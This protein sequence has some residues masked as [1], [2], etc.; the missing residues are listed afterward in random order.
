MAPRKK[1]DPSPGS[2]EARKEK[3]VSVQ[4]PRDLGRMLKVVADA[5]GLSMG[6]LL[7]SLTRE[8]VEGKVRLVMERMTGKAGEARRKTG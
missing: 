5:E 8:I 2:W 7:D 3:F 6:Q 4:V 1:I